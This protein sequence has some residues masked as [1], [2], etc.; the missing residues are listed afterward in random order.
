MYFVVYLTVEPCLV[1]TPSKF[2]RYF[3]SK[4]IPGIFRMKVKIR[5]WPCDFSESIN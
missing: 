4:D 1:A 2:S 5:D 3:I